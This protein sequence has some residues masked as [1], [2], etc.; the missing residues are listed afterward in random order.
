[1]ELFE[2]ERNRGKEQE[3]SRLGWR[4]S[5]KDGG[6]GGGGIVTRKAV[7]EMKV[8]ERECVCARGWKGDGGGDE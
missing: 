6:E 3:Y 8:T 2:K 7:V 1:M 4:I 5:I